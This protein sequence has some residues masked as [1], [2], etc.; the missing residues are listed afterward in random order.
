MP[1]NKTR[2]KNSTLARLDQGTVQLTLHLAWSKTELKRNQI[3]SELA[4]NVEVSG[5]RKGKAPIDKAIGRL[6]PD[7]IIEDTLNSLLPE[8]YTT[9]IKE[10]SIIPAMYPNFEL[11]SA[12]EGRD[13]QIR[14]T[15]AELPKFEVKGYKQLIKKSKPSS[16][17]TIDQRSSA[18]VLRKQVL[19]VGGARG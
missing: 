2:T 11:I 1:K 9:A 7:K 18:K 5:F 16:P 3:I 14:A 13:W 12:K 10:H 17:P 8:A 15:T 4:K 19:K 6:N